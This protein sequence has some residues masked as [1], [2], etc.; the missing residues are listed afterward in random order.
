MVVLKPSAYWSEPT[1]HFVNY[2]TYLIALVAFELF[3]N[4]LIRFQRERVTQFGLSEPAIRTIGYSCFL[5]AGL[6]MIGIAYCSPDMMAMAIVFL[7]SFLL[8]KIQNGRASGWTY[9][10]FGV[11]LGLAYLAR[12]AFLTLTLLY[13]AIAA[14]LLVRQKQSVTRPLIVICASYFVVAAPFV[15]ALSIAKGRF[16]LGDTG[17]PNYAWEIDGAARSIHWQGEPYDIGRP[18]H[19]THRVLSHP[20][21][22][23]FDG[24]VAGTYPP[25]YEPSYWYAGVKPKL[26]LG[27]QMHVLLTGTIELAYLFLRSP[28]A[29][30]WFVLMLLMGIPV[31]LSRRGIL[32]Y[33][34]L[35]LPALV[36]IGIYMIVYMDPRY[37]A[38]SLVLIWMTLLASVS[39]RESL[40]TRA[41]QL[42]QWFG[43][44]C[45]AVLLIFRLAEPARVTARDLLSGHQAERNLSWQLADAFRKVGLN[46]GDRI[47][48]I[49]KS[50]DW[51]WPRLDGVRIVAEVP[52]VWTRDPGLMRRV[53]AN[54]GE[55]NA[56]WHASP[57]VQQRVLNAFRA[58]GAVMVVADFIPKGVSAPGWKRVLRDSELRLPPEYPEDSIAPYTVYKWLSPR[59][60]ESVTATPTRSQPGAR[61]SSSVMKLPS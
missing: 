27:P 50:M 1:L 15:M 57:E 46:P 16:T 5:L 42:V 30:P 35:W 7:I 23:T 31:W 44:L 39:V 40:R 33:W 3:V 37:V 45:V 36:Y 25:W 6:L 29:F 2:A 10:G 56:F 47:A 58:V 49:G 21:T 32:P 22:Y 55:I 54:R 14:F 51:D 48:Y 28:A 12:A 18:L 4:E 13:A 11:L 53:R 17:P 60:T 9:V 41:S 34:F 61:A 52:V 43:F 26:K 38:G 19:P 8:L 20:A 59:P 24:P